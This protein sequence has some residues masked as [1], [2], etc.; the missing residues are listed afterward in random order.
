M[1]GASLLCRLIETFR[2]SVQRSALVN[3]GLM[4]FDSRDVLNRG[5]HCSDQG[6][7]IASSAVLI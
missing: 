3:L 1:A 7:G 4:S 6:L 5:V 2:I